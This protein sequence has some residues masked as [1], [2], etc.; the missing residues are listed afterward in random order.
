MSTLPQLYAL[1]RGRSASLWVLG[2]LSLSRASACGLLAGAALLGACYSRP[3]PPISPLVSGVEQDVQPP[4]IIDSSF[5]TGG[6]PFLELP[7]TPEPVL[8]EEPEILNEPPP[9]ADATTKETSDVTG[10]AHDLLLQPPSE[11]QPPSHVLDVSVGADVPP[12]WGAGEQ[13]SNPE[14][15]LPAAGQQTDQ[16]LNAQ[17]RGGQNQ[18]DSDQIR[19]LLAEVGTPPEWIEPFVA[20]AWCESK[21]SPGAVGD[22]GR[23]LGMWQLAHLW[24]AHAGEDITRWADPDVNARVALSVARYSIARGRSPWEQWS[25]QP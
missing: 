4:V 14:I 20:I 15:A 7:L 10:P 2:R 3:A 13:A 16:S 24:F 12:V 23:S 8:K 17:P 22:S 21:Y 5:V 18:L 25:C 1:V 19:Q 11:L 9:V 6:E